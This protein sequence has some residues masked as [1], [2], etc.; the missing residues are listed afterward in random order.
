MNDWLWLRVIW[1]TYYYYYY[2]SLF[3]FVAKQIKS[4]K[5]NKIKNDEITVRLETSFSWSL[6][7][8]MGRSDASPSASLF[9]ALRVGAL[10]TTQYV[11]TSER[12]GTSPNG[13]FFLCLKPFPPRCC[14]IV[15]DVEEMFV[16]MPEWC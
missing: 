11:V 9:C 7:C 10:S 5:K 6:S 3:P 8:D 12:V 2:C 15:R 14:I 4:N 1:M 13:P 16:G